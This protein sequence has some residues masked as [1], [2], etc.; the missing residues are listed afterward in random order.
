MCGIN[1]GSN[2]RYT[3]KNLS[4]DSSLFQKLSEESGCVSKYLG[5]VHLF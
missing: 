5:C 4:L 2:K 1:S 3:K